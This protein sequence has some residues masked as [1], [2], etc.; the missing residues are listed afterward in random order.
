MLVSPLERKLHAQAAGRK[1]QAHSRSERKLPPRPTQAGGLPG[2]Y[3]APVRSKT[4][5]YSLQCPGH[6]A[7]CRSF[8][9]GDFVT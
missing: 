3:S 1:P 2:N 6:T 9:P 5:C 7:C 4:H 8:D